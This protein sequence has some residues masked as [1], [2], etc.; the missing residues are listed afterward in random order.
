[1]KTVMYRLDDGEETLG[2]I[3]ETWGKVLMDSRLGEVALKLRPS[4]KNEDSSTT[5][6]VIRLWQD[7]IPNEGSGWLPVRMMYGW[8]REEILE[9]ATL[10]GEGVNELLWLSQT[11][12]LDGTRESL[13]RNA[14]QLRALYTRW[15][16]IIGEAPLF[17]EEEGSKIAS[18]A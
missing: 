15:L 5:A 3:Y 12:V 8:T 10:V 1:M 6:E 7:V 13:K 11:A 17:E 2:I 14:E 9:I 4:P 18:L 16:D